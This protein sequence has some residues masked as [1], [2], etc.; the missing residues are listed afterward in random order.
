MNNS[1]DALTQLAASV[2]GYS[3]NAATLSTSRAELATFTLRE[4][5]TAGELTPGMR[6]PEIE[7]AEKLGVSRNTLREA[8][9]LLSQE[10][11]I[12]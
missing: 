3:Q 8:F 4:L 1:Q 7:L 9:R 12:E 6:L 10:K 5:I 2:P 11:L